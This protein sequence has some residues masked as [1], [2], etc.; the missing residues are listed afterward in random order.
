M[1]KTCKNCKWWDRDYQFVGEGVCKIL[2]G[3]DK[4]GV[5][6]DCCDGSEI[7]SRADFGCIHF[8]PKQFPMSG[9]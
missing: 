3:F 8:E 5:Y 9:V 4:P 7:V 1:T 2:S 6:G